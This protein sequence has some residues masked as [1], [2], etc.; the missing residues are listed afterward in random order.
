MK[1]PETILH[2]ST[3]L[4][5]GAGRILKDLALFQKRQGSDV[6]VVVSKTEY[7]GYSNYVEYL[8]E[9]EKGG[10]TVVKCDSLFK[11]DIAQ[12]LQVVDLLGKTSN[13]WKFIHA[14]AA[15][16]AL[17]G[18][19]IASQKNNCT[20]V[21]QSMQGWGE[22][23]TPTQEDQDVF[24]MNGLHAVVAV[25]EASKRLLITKGIKRD[26]I[27]VIPNGVCEEPFWD[28]LDRKDYELIEKM[29]SRFTFLIGCVGS[30][31]RRKNQWAL[32][33]AIEL[34]FARGLD[35]G[36]VLIGEDDGSENILQTIKDKNLGDRIINLGYRKNPRRFF[37][38]FDLFCLP[39]LSEGLPLS[40]LECFC[41]RVLVVA[42]NISSI[43]ELVT[44]RKT[45]FLFDPKEI[46]SIANSIQAALELVNEA[47]TLIVEN[48]RCVFEESYT[49]DAVV[50]GYEKLYQE[51]SFS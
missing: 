44:D 16:P 9:L 51:V 2:L 28:D 19:I 36:L 5:G 8:E 15:I 18:K 35:V 41:D 33:G 49:F 23:K 48:A 3:Y 38:F 37:T 50:K 40:I 34:L 43:T 24:I 6:Q 13:D 7:P 30:I 12:I 46:E 20:P 22:N 25:S 26:L 10:I 21:I 1:P 39:S 11:R 17:I 4:Q 42:S 45:G 27:R 32:I 14:H 31:C 47:R 29:K